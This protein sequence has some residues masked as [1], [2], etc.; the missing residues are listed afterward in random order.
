MD[1]LY[2]EMS[3]S[4]EKGAKVYILDGHYAILLVLLGSLKSYP[5]QQQNLD[6]VTCRFQLPYKIFDLATHDESYIESMSSF[7][8]I[9]IPFCYV[10]SP[11]QHKFRRRLIYS[12]RFRR[13]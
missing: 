7:S 4:L 8:Y 3:I 12:V 1:K 11:S 6:A 2:R 13:G 5:T 9:C 10:L